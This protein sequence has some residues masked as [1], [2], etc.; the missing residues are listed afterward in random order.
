MDAAEMMKRTREASAGFKARIAGALYFLNLLTAALG[1]S[2]GGT[3]GFT[4][5]FTSGEL[6]V[7]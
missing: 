4:S 1:E 7:T 6:A 3:S 2:V 5:G